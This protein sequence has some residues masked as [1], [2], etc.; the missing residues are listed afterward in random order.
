[1]YVR[2]SW[3]Y[4]ESQNTK[5]PRIPHSVIYS[6]VTMSPGILSIPDVR[7]CPIVSCYLDVEH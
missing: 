1:M 3:C 5:Y 7:G 6:G 2:V 4:L